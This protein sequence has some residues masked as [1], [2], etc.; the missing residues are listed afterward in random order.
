MKDKAFWQGRPGMEW[1]AQASALTVGRL[2]AQPSIPT[3]AEVE[4]AI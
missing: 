3:A 2:G 1:G 4:A